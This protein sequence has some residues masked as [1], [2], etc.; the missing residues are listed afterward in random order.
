[1]QF[2]RLADD[3]TIAFEL[4]LPERLTEDDDWMR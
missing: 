4:S 3:L 1:M 2:D